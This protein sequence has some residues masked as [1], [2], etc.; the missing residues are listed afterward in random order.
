ME[1]MTP[2]PLPPPPDPDFGAA[3]E[4]FRRG[5]WIVSLLGGAGMLARMLISDETHKIIYWVRRIIAAAIVGVI[6][7]FALW[8]ANIDGL[9]KSIIMCTAGTFAPEIMEYLRLKYSKGMFDNE[10]ETKKST[11][12]RARNSK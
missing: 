5:G 7:Y 4:D 12:K 10:K 2:T 11:K 9:K 8:G 3:A 1:Q 6:C